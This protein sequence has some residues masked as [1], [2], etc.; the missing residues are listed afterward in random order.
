MKKILLSLGLAWVVLLSVEARPKENWSKGEI[1][2]TTGERMKG[3]LLY[4]PEV[5]VVS[6]KLDDGR[7]RAYGSRQL[8]SFSFWDNKKQQ[9]R[10]FVKSHLP[11]SGREVLFEN[12]ADGALKIQR[13]LKPYSRK[14]L[15]TFTSTTIDE[16]PET[17]HEHGRYQYY[18]QDGEQLMT[19]EH[20][21]RRRFSTSTKRWQKELEEYRYYNNL[22]N[23][24]ASWLKV[25][26]YYNVLEA[27]H[28]PKEYEGR[29]S[30]GASFILMGNLN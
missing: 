18:V 19:I 25:L 6:I 24:I 20:F 8:E 17:A 22:D 5:E 30:V 1:K 16:A 14:R 9:T 21:L 12:I 27:D 29:P 23:G 7:H 2:L 26:L 13:F 10:H 4:A 3:E 15:L 28:N 11:H